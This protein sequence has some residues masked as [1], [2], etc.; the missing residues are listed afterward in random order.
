MLASPAVL[1]LH[2]EHHTLLAHLAGLGQPRLGGEPGGK[3]AHM[4]Q[5]P[6]ARWQR[7]P[8]PATGTLWEAA[9]AMA[10]LQ[11]PFIPAFSA[12]KTQLSRALCSCSHCCQLSGRSFG[13]SNDKCVYTLIQQFQSSEF[14]YQTLFP[15]EPN[16]CKSS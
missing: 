8:Q 7:D 10:P 11:L 1:A 12:T 14:M 6:E 4:D 15:W 2:S 3:E 5:R 9:R 13:N 16:Y